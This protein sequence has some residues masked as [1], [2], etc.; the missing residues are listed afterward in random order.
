MGANVIGT[1]GSEDKLDALATHGLDVGIRTRSGD[2]HDRVMEATGNR[3]VDLVINTVG[4]T[5]FAE[6]VRSMAFEGRLATVG[7]VDNKLT[8][9]IDIQALHS[10][11]LTLF[12]VS[13][14]MRTADMR[15]SSVPPFVADFVPLLASGKIEAIID[16]T[17]PFDQL[18]QAKAYMESNNRLGKIVLKVI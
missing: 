16:R 17:Y 9:E 5:V 1:S 4:G 15:A 13:N 10:K 11:R 14:K 18:P 7:Y 3:G 2:F 12:G 6:C 8:A